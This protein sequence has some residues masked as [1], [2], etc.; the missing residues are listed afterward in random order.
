MRL[1]FDALFVTACTLATN[2]ACWPALPCACRRHP[3]VLFRVR[4]PAYLITSHMFI[5]DGQGNPVGEVHRRWSLLKRNYDLY[6]GKKQFA[7]ISGAC[8]HGKPGKWGR[9]AKDCKD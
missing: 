4:R 8:V 5:E 7:A 1:I 3:Q 2:L 9:W 6:V